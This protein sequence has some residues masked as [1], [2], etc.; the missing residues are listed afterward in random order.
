MNIGAYL[1][2]DW[3]DLIDPDSPLLG[4]GLDVATTTNKKSNP[5]ALA[6]TQK[7][8]VRYPLRL[9][10]S[11]KSRDPEVAYEIVRRVITHIPHGLKVKA[12]NIDATSERFFAVTLKRRLAGVC[13]V[14]MINSSN[15]TTFKGEMMSMKAFLGNQ[16]VNIIEDGFALL[17]N[18]AWVKTDFRLVSRDRGSFVTEVDNEGRHG[19]CFDA[20]KLSL[21]AIISKGGPVVAAGAQVGS[22][23]TNETQRDPFAMRA[24]DYYRDPDKRGRLL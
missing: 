9:L 6:L 17:P 4:L 15:T 7:V 5:S 19:D 3:I 12:L 22:Y 8:G 11:W 13:L 24:A 21:D 2:S 14:R 16:A 20:Y 23:K 1:P 10:V 18:E